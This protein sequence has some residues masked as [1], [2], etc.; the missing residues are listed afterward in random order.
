MKRIIKSLSICC[1]FS[2][3]LMFT[4]CWDPIFHDLRKDVKPEKPTVSG[5]IAAITRYTVGGKEFLMVSAD[6]GLRY[7]DA[8]NEAHGSWSTYSL[9]FNLAKFN[10]DNTSINGQQLLTV[11]S[12]SDTVYIVSAEFRTTGSEGITLPSKINIWGKKI[13][14]DDGSLS[15]DGEWVNITDKLATDYFPVSYDIYTGIVETKFN[16][17]QTN[18]PMAAHRHAYF[19]TYNSD[20]EEYNYYELKGTDV[21]VRLSIANAQ[22]STEAAAKDSGRIYSAAFYKGAIRFFTSKTAYTDETYTN[23]AQRLYYYEYNNSESKHTLVCLTDDNK[24]V[25]INDIGAKVSAIMPCADSILL[26]LGD[27]LAGGGAGGI[28][29]IKITNGEPE[30]SFSD[31]TTNA[32]FQITEGYL[33]LSMINA[34]PQ[35]NE[36]ESAIYAS[37]TFFSHNGVY[38]NVGLWSYYPGRGNWNRE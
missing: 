7:K 8:E 34:T 17:F 24:K 14:I 33:V 3:S 25:L 2:L 23:E 6:D 31:F 32:D 28:K 21:P 11:L 13:A 4:S 16:F 36:T 30:T 35:K 5:N 9:P 1:I 29:K 10:F 18:T 12:S 15:S 20:S 38:E 27:I 37:V 22:D 26:G 19:C